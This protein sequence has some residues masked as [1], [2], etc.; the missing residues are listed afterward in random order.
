MFKPTTHFEQV[1]LK[2]VKKIIGEEI[3][4]ETVTKQGPKTRRKQLEKDSVGTKKKFAANFQRSLQME[5]PE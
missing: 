5:L 3:P 1:P 4:P 2:I